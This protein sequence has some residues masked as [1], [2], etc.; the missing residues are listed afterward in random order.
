MTTHWSFALHLIII[1][2]SH[3]SHVAA[4]T[5]SVE[6]C[7]LRSL[8]SF[9]NWVVC[10]LSMK[11]CEP[12]HSFM[13]WSPCWS[14]CLHVFS[15]SIGC[16]LVLWLCYAKEKFDEVPFCLDLLLF[17]LPWAT[18]LRKTLLE[19]MS[20]NVLLNVLFEKSCSASCPLSQWVHPTITSSVTPFSSCPQSFP[21]SRSFPNESVLHIR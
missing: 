18:D 1:D 6:N 9:Q 13:K 14:P 17:P 7:L 19:F 3:L 2:V 10:D 15:Q 5:S 11:L 16:H 12:F 4:A 20:E 8:P 21:A